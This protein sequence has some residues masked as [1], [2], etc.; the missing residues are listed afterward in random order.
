MLATLSLLQSASL[1]VIIN[2]D[3]NLEYS[4]EFGCELFT[5]SDVLN[6]SH[7]QKKYFKNSK[8]LWVRELKIYECEI[9]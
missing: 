6:I 2:Q 5:M 1:V 3:E 9:K 7:L 8:G 4:D